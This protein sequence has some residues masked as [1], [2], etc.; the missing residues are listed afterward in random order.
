MVTTIISD[1]AYIIITTLF[2]LISFYVKQFLNKHADLLEKQEKSLENKI[3]VDQYNLDKSIAIDIILRVEEEAK[4]FDWSSEIKH[5]KAT[6][7][8]AEKTGLS[9][10]DIYNIIKATVT[11]IKLNKVK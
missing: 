9:P 6:S 4:T 1:I 2:A 5:S 11:K 8:I 3:G 7:L 10:E